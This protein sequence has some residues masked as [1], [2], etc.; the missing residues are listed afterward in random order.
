M[1]ASPARNECDRSREDDR[2]VVQAVL[3][4]LALAI[5]GVCVDVVVSKSRSHEVCYLETVLRR[6]TRERL[7]MRR[8]LC[9]EETSL[10]KMKI[11]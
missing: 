6:A 11:R 5:A 2:R 4:I 7:I 1:M 8:L 10:I 9:D 3:R